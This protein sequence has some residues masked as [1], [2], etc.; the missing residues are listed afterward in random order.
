MITPCEVV[1]LFQIGLVAGC[2]LFQ[3][4]RYRSG[5]SPESS[6]VRLAMADTMLL[7]FGNPGGN[8][9][10]FGAGL[11]YTPIS[12]IN[13]FTWIFDRIL[14][15][16]FQSKLSSIAIAMLIAGKMQFRR[17]FLKVTLWPEY[18]HEL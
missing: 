13:L 3:Y 18:G 10:Q 7:L 15:A 14:T 9:R 17:R 6:P 12:R 1:P 11:L 5:G 16:R 4:A 8:R 2:A